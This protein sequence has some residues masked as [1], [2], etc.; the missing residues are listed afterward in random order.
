MLRVKCKHIIMYTGTWIQI[1]RRYFK[2]L[3]PYA[4]TICSALFRLGGLVLSP[5]R[6]CRIVVVVVCRCRIDLPVFWLS[7]LRLFTSARLHDSQNFP[8]KRKCLHRLKLNPH[9]PSAE[10]PQCSRSPP[11]QTKS[12]NEPRPNAPQ[13]SR[14]PPHQTKSISLPDAP[15]CSR[16]V[17]Q[18]TYV[19]PN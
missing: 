15:Q 5:G 7:S 6:R 18:I 8:S 13:C 3:N 1:N 14:P 4:K 10:A 16:T 2:S 9:S 12:P 11:H 19:Q 17:T